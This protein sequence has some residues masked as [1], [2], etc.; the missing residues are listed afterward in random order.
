MAALTVKEFIGIYGS[1]K[2][3][4]IFADG[5]RLTP[6]EETKVMDIEPKYFSLS[7]VKGELRFYMDDESVDA[8]EEQ[9]TVV[10][11]NGYA[12]ELPNREQARAI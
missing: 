8:K 10:H 12:L 1:N 7:D 4:K 3:V 11:D 2:V 6:D 9:Q 5:K